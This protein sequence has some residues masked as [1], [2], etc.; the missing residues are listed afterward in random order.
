MIELFKDES[1]PKDIK[2]GSVLLICYVLLLIINAMFYIWWSG[3]FDETGAY[4]Q[5]IARCIIFIA[6]ARGLLLK[7]KWA[8]WLGVIFSGIFSIIGFMGIVIL[9]AYGMG[10]ERPYIHID[11]GILYGLLLTLVL[12]FFILLK[13]TTRNYIFK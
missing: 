8:W 5:L 3:Q 9:Q 11:L 12:V 2:Y 1:I 13:S 7:E 6:A 10:Y 4:I